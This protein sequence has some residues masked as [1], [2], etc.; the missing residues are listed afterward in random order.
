MSTFELHPDLQRDG[1]LLG[2]FQLSRVLLVNDSNY[3]W[4]VLIPEIPNTSDTID[5]SLT[6]HK[7]LWEESRIFGLAIMELFNGDKLNIA[8]LGNMT[9]QLHV[10]HIVR[11]QTDP[12]WPAPIWGKHPLVPYSDLEL[13]KVHELFTS[14]N[15]D[16]FSLAAEISSSKV[17]DVRVKLH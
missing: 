13:K 11:Y 9:P 3:P 6:Q 5:L 2:N 15:L 17:L 8:S 4:F 16:N 10:H 1:V 12:A 14:T 7:K